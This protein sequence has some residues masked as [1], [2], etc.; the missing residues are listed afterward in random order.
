[1]YKMV[2]RGRLIAGMSL[3]SALEWLGLRKTV[4]EEARAGTPL[5][6]LE[7]AA[8]AVRV[9]G[10]IVRPETPLVAQFSGVPCVFWAATYLELDTIA[11]TGSRTGD[12]HEQVIWRQHF[13]TARSMPFEIAEASGAR[14]RVEI[15]A[16]WM[17]GGAIDAMVPTGVIDA[18][19]PGHAN[20]VWNER[21]GNIELTANGIAWQA[22]MRQVTESQ[23]LNGMPADLEAFFRACGVAPTQ[24]MGLLK[25]HKFFE[26]A[27]FVGTAVEIIG[28]ARK[29]L[30]PG[31]VA[32]RGGEGI[33]V[34]RP[35][36]IS[37]AG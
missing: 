37:V 6:S 7:D 31:G 17:E 21:R 2:P 11:M 3:R 13:R 4:L 5:G 19:P 35:R 29:G 15:G 36:F 27:L 28:D 25:E 32:Y 26:A 9:R 1:M 20:A 14:A 12:Q 10:T 22:P 18:L 8:G 24:F 30:D 16:E 34:L 33:T 23:R